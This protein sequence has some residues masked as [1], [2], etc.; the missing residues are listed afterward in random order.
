MN[1]FAQLR[2][3]LVAVAAAALLVSPLAH[4]GPAGPDVPGAVAVEA[5]HKVFLV[6]HAVGVQIYS[7][8]ATSSG[9]EWGF[10]A[11]RADLFGDNGKLIATHFGGPTWQ[12]RDGSTVVAQRVDGVNVDPTAID[13]LLLSARSTAAGANGD[14]LT[15]TTFIQRT[16]TAGGR[17]PAAST[18]NAATVGTT[19]EI[20]YTAD[21][22]FWK[23]TGR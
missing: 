19:V 4:A 9:F 18:C 14:R 10:V 16:A 2:T 3:L 6:G 8:N 21:Y 20:P 5:G 11:P 7:C 1:R 22:H 15:A 23:A 12:A 17:A 13:W